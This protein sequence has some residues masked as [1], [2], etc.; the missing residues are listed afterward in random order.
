MQIALTREPSPRLAEGELTYMERSAVDYDAALIQH[1]AYCDTLEACGVQVRVLPCLDALPDSVFVEDTAVVLDEVAVLLPLGAA[2]RRAES[3]HMG[4]VL[5]EYRPVVEI[6]DSA[7]IEGG[8]VL[9]VGRTLLVG[10]ST[11]TSADGIAALT[12]IGAQYG[13][14]VLPVEVR[15]CLHFKTGCT[16]LDN[17]T[18]L[19]N[20]DWLDVD[21]LRNFE[22][23]NIS[24]SEPW[25]AN[26][27][28]IGDWLIADS[29]S[30]RTTE[31]IAA[32]GHEVRFVDISE[33]AKVEAGLTCMS[34]V[35][36]D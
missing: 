31:R 23:V 13:Y 30:R 27:L 34:L 21:A 16:A 22:L 10:L 15:G 33:F 6:P 11:R 3:A 25:A 8:D 26:V 5:A 4:D 2:S 36:S 24:S 12:S 1:R 18:L 20:P 29:A 14:R 35:F 7:R 32:R 9:R 19:V 28:R 17:S